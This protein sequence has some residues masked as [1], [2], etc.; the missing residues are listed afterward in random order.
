MLHGRPK[1]RGH[2]QLEDN[3]GGT[4]LQVKIVGAGKVSGLQDWTDRQVHG[5]A[6]PD[7]SWLGAGKSVEGCP[8]TNSDL[9]DIPGILHKN[10]GVIQITIKWI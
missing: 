3:G 1:L 5:G 4:I 2:I 8:V 6:T 9:A 7:P 10:G